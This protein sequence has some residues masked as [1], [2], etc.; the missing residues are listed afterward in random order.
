MN[1]QECRECEQYKYI[2]KD[3]LCPSCFE[4]WIV[5]FRMPHM[6]YEP[7]VMKEGLSEREAKEVAEESRRLVAKPSD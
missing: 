7:E 5:V 4:E 2:E 1:F 3:D 6:V